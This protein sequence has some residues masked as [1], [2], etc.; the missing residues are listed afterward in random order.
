MLAIH[1]KLYPQYNIIQERRLQN[2]NVEVERRSGFD[3]RSSE[4][5]KLDTNLTRDIF[6]VKSKVAKVSKIQPF[7]AQKVELRK[8]ES[9]KIQK[10][11]FTHSAPKAAQNSIKTDQFIKTTKPD[12]PKPLKKDSKPPS[13]FGVLGVMLGSVLVAPLLG[14]AGIGIAIG[15]GVYFGAKLFRASIVSHLKNKK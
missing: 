11:T 4:R 5:V 1:N 6:E 8:A 13:P 2:S 10:T 12:S 3:R 14:A 9:Q 15:L 7:E